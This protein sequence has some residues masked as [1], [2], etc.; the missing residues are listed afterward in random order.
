MAIPIGRI[1]ALEDGS[2]EAVI[3]TEHGEERDT[4]DSEREAASWL[5]R[6]RAWCEQP[7]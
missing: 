3:E 7:D 4:F 2:F 6:K 5:D 1:Q